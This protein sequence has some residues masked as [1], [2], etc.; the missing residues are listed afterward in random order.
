MW[1]AI[2]QHYQT[3]NCSMVVFLRSAVKKIHIVIFFSLKSC[4]LHLLV[5]LPHQS[6]NPGRSDLSFV[7]F[8]PDS[9][10]HRLAP[11]TE[12]VLKK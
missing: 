12:K 7:L 3:R 9:P 1:E 10:E 5:C 4:L 11:G 8:I 2:R 6:V